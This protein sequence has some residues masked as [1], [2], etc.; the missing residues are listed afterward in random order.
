MKT[1]NGAVVLLTGGS[2]GIGPVIAEALARRGAHLA[3]V[4]RSQAALQEVANRLSHLGTRVLATPADLAEVSQREPLVDRVRAEFG[5][6]DILINNAALQTEGAF[7]ELPLPSINETV[8]A[9]LIA[10]MTLARLVLP[11]MLRRKAGQIVNIASVA[12][13]T[14]IPYEALYSGTKAGLTGW[15]RAL[16]LE[17]ANTGVHCSTIFPGFVTE[18]GMFAKF[19]MQSPWLAGS[20]TPAEVA[21]AVVDSIEHEK[22]EIIVNSR[23]L[24]YS[25]MLNELSPAVGDWL[26]RASGVVDFQRRKIASTRHKT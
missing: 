20:C 25:F 1:L 8:E 22:S 26:M 19:R 16:R 14:G 15:T 13:K 17:L 21:A 24:R 10:P 7:D 6:I 4:A 2:R 23:P 5:R 9:N 11:E 18:V 12:G 3:L